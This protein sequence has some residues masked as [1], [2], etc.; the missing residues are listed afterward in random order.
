MD[1]DEL[2]WFKQFTGRQ[3]PPQEPCKEGW[4]IC[5]RRAGKSFVLA[6]VAVYLACFREYRQYL[7]PGERGTI[8]IIASDKKQARTILNYVRGFLHHIP[9]LNEML[10]RETADTFDITNGVSIEIHTASF[11]STRGYT[12]CAALLDEAAFFPSD[13]YSSDPD[14]EILR[15]L[16]PGLATI[17]GSVLLV[18]SS[19]YAK[20]GIVYE[21]FRDHFANENDPVLVWKA[22]TRQMNETI[23]DAL[24][25]SELQADPLAAAAEW[26]AEFRGDISS[27]ITKEAL[28]AVTASV[29]ERPPM[30]GMQYVAFVDP[31][32]GSGA[33]SFT[34][35]IAHMEDETSVLDCI[36]EVQP[37][38]SP[39]SISAEFANL[40][41]T[42]GIR[43]CQGDRFAG[44][45]PVEVFARYG[46]KYEQSAKAKSELYLTL[47]PQINS[48]SVMLLK[49]TRLI[50]QLSALE[51]RS[52]RG[53]RDAIDHGPKNHDDVANAVAGAL[54]L[55]AIQAKRTLGYGVVNGYGGGKI[56]WK[57]N[58]PKPR[59]WV[60]RVMTV[61]QMKA[62]SRAFEGEGVVA[63]PK[64]L[65]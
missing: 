33:D 9:M 41:F 59:A 18:A 10:E 62:R 31:A 63:T 34:L 57:D 15:A 22:T 50:L 54:L 40:M 11:R 55:A 58:E 42:Y 21:S 48:G 35:A 52:T 7:M 25:E 32:G 23:P 2:Q 53:G 44:L 27:F 13:E 43:K 30:P 6:L 37:P 4:L 14:V 38:F 56:T 12:L 49:N 60:R 19:P 29:G 51:R 28:D 39:E 1:D 45:W 65:N 8:A 16:R 5:G 3:T 20:R 47:L 17:P 64:G 46:V 24:V 26:L 36:R 61:E